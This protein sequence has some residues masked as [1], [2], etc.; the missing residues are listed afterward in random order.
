MNRRGRQ[1]TGYRHGSFVRLGSP[2]QSRWL[3]VFKIIRY[4]ALV[5]SASI[6]LPSVVLV[7]PLFSR[8]LA[9][10]QEFQHRAI[11]EEEI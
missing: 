11:A 9:E 8:L 4:K 3:S 10:Q 2:D 6:D 5:E 7:S 1:G